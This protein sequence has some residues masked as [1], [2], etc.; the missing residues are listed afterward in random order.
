VIQFRQTALGV[1]LAGSSFWFAVHIDGGNPAAPLFEP[2]NRV[3]QIESFR[4]NGP[5]DYWRWAGALSGT[6]IV[7]L[8]RGQGLEVYVPGS[9]NGPAL[10]VEAWAPGDWN[11]DSVVNSADISAFLSAWVQS[12]GPDG[13]GDF[14]LDGQ[15]TSADISAFLSAWVNH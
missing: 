12:R 2:A 14:N 13:A 9:L 15:V 5:D 7:R 6:T 1:M 11:F 8:N 4:Q 3:G 10:D